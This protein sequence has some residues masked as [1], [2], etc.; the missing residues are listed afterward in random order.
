VAGNIDTNVRTF[1]ASKRGGILIL[2]PILLSIY[3]RRDY[4]T[5]MGFA[6]VQRSSD[7]M[8][9]GQV[10]NYGNAWETRV[11]QD[12]L[13]SQHWTKR[14]PKKWRTYRNLPQ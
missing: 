1:P 14:G 9:E 3:I 12:G 2:S 8:L 6:S 4:G 11:R 5:R 13:S 10:E 7:N